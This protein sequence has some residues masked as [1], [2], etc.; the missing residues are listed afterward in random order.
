VQGKIKPGDK[1]IVEGQLQ[2]INGG[3][4]AVNKNGHHTPTAQTPI[5]AQ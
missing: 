4:V 2:V 1:V 3:K 5:G